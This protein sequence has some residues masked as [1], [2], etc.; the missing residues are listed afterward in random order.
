MPASSDHQTSTKPRL[1]G[2]HWIELTATLSF[3][4]TE[5]FANWVDDELAQMERELDFYVTPQSL[6]KSLRGNR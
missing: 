6:R 5:V 3:E 1:E 4:S 2:R